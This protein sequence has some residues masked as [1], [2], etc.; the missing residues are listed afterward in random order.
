MPMIDV[1]APVGLF[2]AGSERRLAEELTRALLRAEGAPAAGPFLHNTAAYLHL[3]PA[4]AVHT[5]AAGSA[6][7]V[8]VQVLTPPGA[9][10][11]EG[12][13]AFVAEATDIVVAVSGDP[14]QRQR[15][16][17]LLG[18]AAEGGWGIAGVAFG[19]AEFA[20]ARG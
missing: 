17:V 12:Q 6:A 13:R 2:P 14:T 10:S 15:T 1:Y 16:W 5:A 20:A 4:E 19:K 18:E 11:R 7:T 3:L 8:R 9:L